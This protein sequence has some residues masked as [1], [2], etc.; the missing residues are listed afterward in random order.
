MLKI[1]APDGLKRVG[2]DGH[3]VVDDIGLESAVLV[4][5]NF[6]QAMVGELLSQEQ[7]LVM[8]DGEDADFGH[9]G[10]QVYVVLYPIY[11]EVCRREE[12]G[13]LVFRTL[14]VQ[15]VEPFQYD[16]RILG[17][18]PA[19]LGLVDLPFGVEEDLI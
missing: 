11:V 10:G 15:V 8:L 6:V 19:E 1:H 2:V 17:V 5:D 4:D 14:P 7:G 16:I 9:E 3:I 18:Q 13:L 12:L